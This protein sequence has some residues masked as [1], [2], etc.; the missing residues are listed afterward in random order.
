MILSGCLSAG[1]AGNDGPNTVNQPA[2][3]VDIHVPAPQVVDQEKVVAELGRVKHD[4]ST[5]IASSSN[6]TQN[7]LSGLVNASVSKVAER[8]TG[9]EASIKDLLTIN[10][11]A[12]AN[13]H[14]S[15][16]S[17]LK[18]T[19]TLEGRVEAV[20]TVSTDLKADLKANLNVMNEMKIELGKL[21]LGA[22]AGFNNKMEQLQQDLKNTAG[23]DVNYLPKEAVYMFVTIISALCALATTIA[24]VMGRNSR[25]REKLETEKER[26]NVK[27]WQQVAMQSIAA[28]DPDKAAAITRSM[29]SPPAQGGVA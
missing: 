24:L 28:L 23:R 13:V 26:E 29:P 20:A 5:E 18:A 25:L 21:N 3:K 2:P 22:Q 6:N 11:T 10:N 9:V 16:D 14:T 15:F 1:R 4:I 8:V 27:Y 19:T 17:I 12:T 7:A